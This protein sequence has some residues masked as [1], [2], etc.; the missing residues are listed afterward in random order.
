MVQ[1][2]NKLGVYGEGDHTFYQLEEP[3]ALNVWKAM[4]D[5]DLSS[6]NQTICAEWSNFESF[7]AW[8]N[9]NNPNGDLVIT[10]ALK[11]SYQISSTFNPQSLSFVPLPI[12][13]LLTPK[14]K[15][16]LVKGVKYDLYTD[17]FHA[18][19]PNIYVL[20]G[21]T[22]QI[23]NFIETGDNVENNLLG[24]YL[25]EEEAYQ[26]YVKR[27]S[28]L[29]RQIIDDYEDRG[30]IS[31]SLHLSLSLFTFPSFEEAK[32]LLITNQYGESSHE[33]K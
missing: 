33:F 16:R 22:F 18:I 30:L 6:K 24:M 10:T 14:V 2:T 4:W 5:I 11:E 8:Y 20:R 3:T 31:M 9:L 13:I 21:L 15:G 32:E 23:L 12:A 25:T 1:F 29:L 7:E 19:I 27:A 28:N 17:K 26:A